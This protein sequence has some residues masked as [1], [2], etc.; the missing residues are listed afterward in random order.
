MEKYKYQLSTPDWPGSHTQSTALE[1]DPF[2]L[3]LTLIVGFPFFFV[4]FAIRYKTEKKRAAGG[5]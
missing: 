3:V 4:I 5:N 1:F 2:S